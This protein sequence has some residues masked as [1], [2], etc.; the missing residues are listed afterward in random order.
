MFSFFKKKINLIKEKDKILK[1]FNNAIIIENDIFNPQL[2][3]EI[4]K[5]FTKRDE[6]SLFF[7]PDI[8]DF[9]SKIRKYTYLYVIIKDKNEDIL[10]IFILQ[11][12]LIISGPVSIDNTNHK[13]I[14]NKLHEN[15]FMYRGKKH[16]GSIYENLYQKDYDCSLI[17]DLNDLDNLKIKK[18]HKH[19]INKGRKSKAIVNFNYQKNKFNDFFK[20]SK[21]PNLKFS[22]NYL[23]QMFK[24]LPNNFF[25]ITYYKNDIFL[26][27]AIFTKSFDKIHYFT[28][29]RNLSENSE[30]QHLLIYESL[31]YFQ[32]LGMNK[33]DF[34]G[35]SYPIL[36][37]W[38]SFKKNFG[39]TIVVRF[40]R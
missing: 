8:I 21:F 2:K 24:N 19:A 37:S 5:F 29:S 13:L 23:S 7:D 9:D 10:S 35:I 17:I 12:N 22:K 25:L 14:T 18:G 36:S 6:N 26:S 27:G 33:I 38:D 39:S 40:T 31:L 11:N 32:K 15:F 1:Y 3:K 30:T 20:F 28:S 4:Q 16:T 34:G